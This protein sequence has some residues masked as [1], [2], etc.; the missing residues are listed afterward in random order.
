M[1]SRSTKQACGRRAGLDGFEARTGAVEAVLRALS[2]DGTIGRWRDEAYPV[3]GA[4]FG[5]HL[6]WM[7]RS[8]IPFF[9]VRARGVHVNGFVR[10]GER[11]RMWIG[12]R[13]ADKATYP[14]MLDNF[15]AGGQ[16][17]GHRPDGERDQGSGRGGRGAGGA[18]RHRAPGGRGLLLP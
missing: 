6:M 17:V 13:A 18:R 11:I 2:E 1:S 4:L 5:P 14:G 7:D 16:P 9:G 10:D 12:R 8:A 15:V 3:G